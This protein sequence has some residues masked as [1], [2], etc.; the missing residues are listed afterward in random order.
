MAATARVRP[1]CLLAAALVLAAT[2]AAGITC[3][4]YTI[5]P[6]TVSYEGLRLEGRPTSFTCGT[7]ESN[8]DCYRQCACWAEAHPDE[9]QTCD[10]HA[11]T[12]NDTSRCGGRNLCAFLTTVSNVAVDPAST[13]TAAETNRMTIDTQTGLVFER[14][15]VFVDAT[16]SLLLNR[17]SC[18]YQANHFACQTLCLYNERC[19]AWMWNMNPDLQCGDDSPPYNA[20]EG[21]GCKNR[22]DM[23]DN[24]CRQGACLL[25][26]GFYRFLAGAEF[27]AGGRGMPGQQGGRVPGRS[28]SAVG[29]NPNAPSMVVTLGDMYEGKIVAGNGLRT[30]SVV[31]WTLQQA[32]DYSSPLPNSTCD[33]SGTCAVNLPCDQFTSTVA[34]CSDLCSSLNDHV[35]M[36]ASMFSANPA[37]YAIAPRSTLPKCMFYRYTQGPTSCGGAGSKTGECMMFYSIG[38][39]RSRSSADDAKQVVYGRCAS[40]PLQAG[41]KVIKLVGLDGCVRTN[42]LGSRVC[43]Q[44]NNLPLLWGQDVGDRAVMRLAAASGPVGS[45]DDLTGVAVTLQS[46]ARVVRCPRRSYLAPATPICGNTRVAMAKP[47][48]GQWVLERAGLAAGLPPGTCQFYIRSVA[49][50]GCTAQYLGALAPTGD[51]PYCG[52]PVLGMHKKTSPANASVLLVWTVGPAPARPPG[53]PPRAPARP[54]P[55]PRPKPLPRPPHPRPRSKPRP[56]P[57]DAAARRSALER[58]AGLRTDAAVD[59][60]LPSRGRLAQGPTCQSTFFALPKVSAAGATH[61]VAYNSTAEGGS[62]GAFALAYC[63]LRS[64][65][66]AAVG[67]VRRGLL[68]AELAAAPAA[69]ALST[70][71]PATGEVCSGASCPFIAVIECVP[72]GASACVP[73][74]AGN[75][76]LGNKGSSNVGHFNTGNSN[77]GSRN[78]GNFNIGD[79]NS[80]S[81]CVGSYNT[82]DGGLGT[83]GSGSLVDVDAA[84]K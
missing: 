49:R 62:D 46:A 22:P 47:L 84:K 64:A 16:P 26:S 55:P 3:N 77:V 60:E 38:K 7:A 1:W 34:A 50:A 76:G 42:Y 8:L 80:G 65:S 82:H 78:V 48:G 63:R 10:F 72:A 44:T 13:S 19:V 15:G 58:Q 27:N 41:R 40:L 5:D 51:P 83:A 18:N 56:P 31:G 4:E 70:F 30:P 6:P 2:R 43:R 45:P 66:F 57:P 11:F 12:L 39:R 32:F 74:E 35:T 21:F 59:S 68:P 53:P 17:A 75:I 24:S 71:S 67:A 52:A 20:G 25:F 61:L 73:D 81:G 69:A 9:S 79:M 36:T 14:A 28:N 37:V 33:A 54:K 23:D 29:S